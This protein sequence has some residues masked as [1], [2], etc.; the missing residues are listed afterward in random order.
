MSTCEAGVGHQEAT[1][2]AT[3]TSTLQGKHA[4]QLSPQLVKT[5]LLFYELKTSLEHIIIQSQVIPCIQRYVSKLDVMP[6]GL[7][8]GAPGGLGWERV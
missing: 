6:A 5:L 1:R 2:E 8:P 3:W 4:C 7:A